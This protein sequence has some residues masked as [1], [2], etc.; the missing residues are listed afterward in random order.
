MILG[1]F[2]N[3]EREVE[4]RGDSVYY[5]EGSIV[6]YF[7]EI[8]SPEQLIKLSEIFN[9]KE[10][11]FSHKDIYMAFDL[12]ERNFCESIC[13]VLDFLFSYNESFRNINV[14]SF[15]KTVIKRF[16]TTI[17]L[18]VSSIIN[19]SGINISF[20]EA[21]NKHKGFYHLLFYIKRSEFI[22]QSLIILYYLSEYELDFSRP[23]EFAPCKHDAA[24]G[25][26]H[27]YELDDDSVQNFVDFMINIFE[28]LNNEY[29]FSCLESLLKIANC[30]CNKTYHFKLL[31]LILD[32]FSF[33]DT[34]ENKMLSL[35]ILCVLL[36]QFDTIK[37]KIFDFLRDLLSKNFEVVKQKE[38]YL[39]IVCELL[40][41]TITRYNGI[42]YIDKMQIFSHFLNHANN[43]PFYAK[44]YMFSTIA[45]VVNTEKV[46]LFASY[47]TPD[48]IDGFF[49]LLTHCKS[50]DLSSI[51]NALHVI[52][53]SNPP[54]EIINAYVNKRTH[55][56]Y[57]EDLYE[58]FSHIDK[59]IECRTTNQ[60][61]N[62][63][64][65]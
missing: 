41:I 30:E 34:Y 47:I 22:E 25:V 28:E 36:P 15:L 46:N 1:D 19:C 9:D 64:I 17:D 42:Y 54:D 21:F 61:Q 24:N 53:R 63:S 10:K 31:H 8:N 23:K 16:P 27:D 45:T 59:Y 51:L 3:K 50:E 52:L 5:E 11:L 55:M 32:K 48:L 2:V 62:R 20:V 35:K 44:K 29:T 18:C 49:E 7:M 56:E 14:D 4:Q 65:L 39:K 33:F 60:T 58:I 26:L 12:F 43:V 13:L 38:E 40:N 6:P 37:S 57:R